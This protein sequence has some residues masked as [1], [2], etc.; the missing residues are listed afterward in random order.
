MAS[1]T[2]DSNAVRE[3]SYKLEWMIIS[4]VTRV[5]ISNMMIFLLVMLLHF[6]ML[7]IFKLILL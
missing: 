3:V 4:A 7:N 2:K 6:C 5:F 1:I